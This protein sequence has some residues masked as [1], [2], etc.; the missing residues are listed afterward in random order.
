MFPYMNT[1]RMRNLETQ[2]PGFLLR[3]S[4][5]CEP[6]NMTLNL[7]IFKR[8]ILEEINGLDESYLYGY[9]EPILILKI[10]SMG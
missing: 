3:G 6:S 9:Q 2:M 10:R 4:Q 8:T 7:N 1:N 5:T